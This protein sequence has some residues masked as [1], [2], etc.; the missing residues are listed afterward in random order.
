M[1]VRIRS[2]AV[3]LLCAFTVIL[4]SGCRVNI[5]IGTNDKLTGESY[6][7]AEKYQAGTFVYHAD[8]IREVEV[9][10]RSGEVDIIESDSAELSVRESGSELPE[11]A[12][13]H[14]YLDDGVLRIRFCASGAIIQVNTMDKHLSLEI[15]KGIDL[16]VHTTSALT[17]A[18]ALNQKDILIAAHSGNTEL[19]TVTGE[20]IDLSSSSGTI[21]ADSISGWSVKCSASSGSVD[22]GTVSTSALDCSTSSGGVAAGDVTAETLS[23]TTSSGSVELVLIEVPVAEIYT[24][25]GKVNLTLPKGGAEILFDS[26]S[27]RL[28]TDCACER[29]GDLY[30][31]ANGESKLTVT[32]S[33][34]S[35]EIQ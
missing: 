32:T 8:E 29:K 27:G 33:S 25:S 14:C 16:S 28:L 13:M 6:P 7:D 21:R 26:G 11:D 9:Y 4:L 18:A 23:M 22:L 20:N 35:L 17:K 24:S 3:L 15:P 5:S 31:F 30:V 12:A 2:T 1:N 34:G 19:G 10:W